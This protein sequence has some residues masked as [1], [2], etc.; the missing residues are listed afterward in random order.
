MHKQGRFEQAVEKYREALRLNPD[1]VNAQYNWCI[2]SL[3]LKRYAEADERC[4]KAIGL[5]PFYLKAYL[6]RGEA[7]ARR[8]EKEEASSQFHKA[9]EIE[10]E[11][12]PLGICTSSGTVSHSFSF[13][14]ADAVIVLS[15]SAALADAAATAI[16]NI[17][18]KQDDIPLGIEFAQ[19]I[20]GVGGVVV[21]KGDNMGLWGEVRISST[22]AK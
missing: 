18:K 5:N 10:P 14:K 1:L 2:A 17:I 22:P 16:A 20:E 6:G 7:L 3:A 12:T 11:E 13:G 8:G 21:I 19:G 9:L 4:A 15:A